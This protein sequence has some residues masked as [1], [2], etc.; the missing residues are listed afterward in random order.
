MGSG[1]VDT[2]EAWRTAGRELGIRVQALFEA[3]NGQG[4]VHRFAVYL[5]D[6]GCVKSIL[7]LAAVPP[8]WAAHEKRF[9]VP[10]PRATDRRSLMPRSAVRSRDLRSSTS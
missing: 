7:V 8:E 5:P 1:A 4:M 2:A 9:I 3:A 10:S 6:F